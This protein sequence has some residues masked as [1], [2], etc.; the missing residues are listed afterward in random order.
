VTE[1]T[2]PELMKQRR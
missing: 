1:I 2:Q